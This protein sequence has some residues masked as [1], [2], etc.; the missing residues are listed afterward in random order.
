MFYQLIYIYRLEPC[1]PN[2]M[3]IELGHQVLFFVFRRISYLLLR[4]FFSV[5]RSGRA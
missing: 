3:K 5:L 2:K 1:Y 4:F